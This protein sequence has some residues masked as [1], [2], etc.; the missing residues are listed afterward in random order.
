MIFLVCRVVKGYRVSGADEASPVPKV[1]SAGEAKRS[2][3]PKVGSAGEA[4]RSPVP[5]IGSNGKW[6]NKTT[7]FNK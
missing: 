3:V 4:T 5:K 7:I 2:P 1:G 6:K